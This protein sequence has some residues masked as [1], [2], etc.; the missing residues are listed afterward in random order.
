MVAP[1]DT[2]PHQD[3]PAEKRSAVGAPGAVERG[4]DVRNVRILGEGVRGGMIA[5]EP[6]PPGDGGWRLSFRTR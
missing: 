5:P 2:L 1:E 4:D 6:E 3:R